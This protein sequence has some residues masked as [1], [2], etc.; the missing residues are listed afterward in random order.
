MITNTR[1]Y[2]ITKA[3]AEKFRAAIADAKQE[4]PP[5]NVHPKLYAAS[6]VA[7]RMQLRELEAQL[8]AYDGLKT[9][10]GKT[11]LAGRLEDLEVLLCQ[12]RTA[13]DWTQKQLGDAV[14]LH[15]QKIQQY[16][17]GGYARASLTRIRDVLRALGARVTVELTLTPRSSGPLRSRRQAKASAAR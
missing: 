3:Q 10:R 14:G 2:A 11:R 9:A 8:R 6:I 15:E 5:A 17:A 13:R 7:M 1:A 12:A 4:S 16:E